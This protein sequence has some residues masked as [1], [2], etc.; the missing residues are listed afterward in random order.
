MMPMRGIAARGDALGSGSRREV[1]SPGIVK[2]LV[3]LPWLERRGILGFVE[4]LR[5]GSDLSELTRDAFCM[6]LGR[7]GRR[8]AARSSS[9]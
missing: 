1:L 8:A 6:T 9:A 3:Y 4:V 5:E 2:F 7:H